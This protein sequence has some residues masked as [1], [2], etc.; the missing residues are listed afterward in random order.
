MRGDCITNCPRVS[1]RVTGACNDARFC[2]GEELAAAS[3]RL[4][5][6]FNQGNLRGSPRSLQPARPLGDRLLE[7]R[8]SRRHVRPAPAV[9]GED[10]RGAR[11][12]RRPDRVVPAS[13]QYYSPRR[14]FQRRD[15]RSA[16]PAAERWLLMATILTVDDSPS[17][18]QMIK[19][20]AGAGRAQRA[21][22][23][24]RRA[25]TRQGPGQQ[26]RPRHHRSQHAGDERSGADQ[27]AAQAAELGRAA[28]RL[29][30]HGIQRRR[31]AG[32]QELPAPP[33]G[34]PS[35][36]SRSSCSPSSARL[37]RS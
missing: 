5:Y 12:T 2:R 17:I 30:D 3:F 22:S 26:V 10:R 15:D 11:T 13:A 23:R 27:G 31:E 8:Q 4:Q 29:P 28:D 37:V 34:S 16:F 6:Q 32:G 18:R 9:D 35:R 1:R 19:V 7:R 36:S 24:R 14:L 33:A 20:D 21:R 25:G